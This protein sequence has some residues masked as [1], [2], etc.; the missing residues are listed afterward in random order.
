[1]TRAPR[2]HASRS[3]APRDE[4]CRAPTLVI[5]VHVEHVEKVRALEA[6]KAHKDAAFPGAERALP[7]QALGQAARR[8][9]PARGP[10]VELLGRI[11]ARVHRMHR[12]VEELDRRTRVAHGKRRQP[13]RGAGGPLAHETPPAG[14]AR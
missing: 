10:R 13:K 12:L 7:E 5:L 6:A 8:P 1:M 9:V 4:A 2:S 3:S 14:Y 11:V